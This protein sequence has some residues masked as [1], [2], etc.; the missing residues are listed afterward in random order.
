VFFPGSRYSKLP[1]YQIVKAD[2]TMVTVTRLPLPS[3][4]PILGRHPRQ[5]GQRLDLIAYH[6]LKDATAFWQLCDATN[7]VV[8]DA[9][10]MH[11][12][13]SIP[14]EASS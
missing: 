1:Q 2:G 7:S 14:G 9:L 10:A 6:F 11:S 3:N 13:I 8:P 4:A 12:L 5:N